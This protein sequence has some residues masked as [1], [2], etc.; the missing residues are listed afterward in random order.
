VDLAARRLETLSN[1]LP[2]PVETYPEDDL[3]EEAPFESW[4]AMSKG[5]PQ[6]QAARSAVDAVR[7]SEKAAARA[8]WPTLSAN[9]QEHFTNS[10]LFLGGNTTAYTLQLVAAFRIDYTSF[11][12]QRAQSAA[13][14]VQNVRE[15]RTQRAVDDATY[16][17][18]R[19][20]Q[21][22]IIKSRS[23]RTEQQSAN[24]AAK[25]A[26]ERYAAGVA[27]QLDVTQAQRDAFLADASRIQADAQLAA[28]RVNLRLAAG[29]VP[30]L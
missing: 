11:A 20:V 21:A 25:L 23:A 6:T 8:L 2:T 28:A 30:T 27:T 12:T 22:G 16:E 7:H 14:A 9:A 18:F 10:T 1:L 19:R 29:Q 3:H 24:R 26:S 4:R 17:A 15:E 5:A 13:L